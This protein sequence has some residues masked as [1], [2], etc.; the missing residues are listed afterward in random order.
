ME[1]ADPQQGPLIER[2]QYPRLGLKIPVQFRNVLK[3]S[4]RYSNALT[5]D[6]SAGGMSLISFIP[7]AKEAKLVGLLELPGHPEPIRAIVRVAWIQ[8]RP[9]G[10]S[11]NTGLQFIGIVPEN[12]K[13]IADLVERGVVASPPLGSQ[14]AA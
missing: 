14:A 13:S 6:L 3:P 9:F 11:F 12:Q 1:V 2:R 7:L 10:E 5:H 8:E 4:D